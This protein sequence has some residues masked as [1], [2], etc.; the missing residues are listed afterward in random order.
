MIDASGIRST[1]V[2][3]I[4]SSRDNLLGK[5]DQSRI[6]VI[7]CR[8]SI[9]SQFCCRQWGLF[10]TPHF[11]GFWRHFRNRLSR[12][13]GTQACVCLCNQLW[14]WES[15]SCWCLGIDESDWEAALG[16]YDEHS[17]VW[18]IL[19]H[20]ALEIINGHSGLPQTAAHSCHW[21]QGTRHEP[22]ASC[23]HTCHLT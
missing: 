18:S 4:S 23:H 21:A 13:F 9:S 17:N 7:R 11:S 2:T 20:T 19:A 1:Q 6:K 22:L 15:A 8:C 14:S 3:N 5:I 10:S 16:L 12:Y